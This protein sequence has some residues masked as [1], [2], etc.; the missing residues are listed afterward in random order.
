M[1]VLSTSMSDESQ[2]KCPN[3]GGSGEIA[4]NEWTLDEYSEPECYES[5]NPCG[6]CNATGF[7]DEND[8]H[9]QLYLLDQL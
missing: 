8:E 9:Y 1:G 5:C 7:V 6:F 3:C 4:T 2:I